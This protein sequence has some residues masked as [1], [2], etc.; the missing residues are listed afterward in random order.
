MARLD[1]R[2]AVA[3][4]RYKVVEGVRLLDLVVAKLSARANVMDMQK[5]RRCVSAPLAHMPVSR[6]GF[7]APGLP[8]FLPAQRAAQPVYIAS[9]GTR[10]CPNESVPA[11]GCAKQ[12]CAI[13]AAAVLKFA[14]AVLALT[15]S[16]LTKPRLWPSRC[17]GN[18]R[19]CFRRRSLPFSGSLVGV[20]AITR[21]RAVSFPA[22]SF[23]AGANI[24]ALSAARTW[25]ARSVQLPRL[26]LAAA[27]DVLRVIVGRRG[28][29]Q[30][31]VVVAGSLGRISLNALTTPDALNSNHAF[32]IPHGCKYGS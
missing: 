2:V 3:A 26:R 1:R 13:V 27:A 18:A 15:R 6:K 8:E 32:I 31:A 5:N 24:H 30:R 21:L 4:N 12:V 22:I 9:R 16:V 19:P 28:A 23:I 7:F 20:C 29:R 10:V 25:L 14:P 11:L 17:G